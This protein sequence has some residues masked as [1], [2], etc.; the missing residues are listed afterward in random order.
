MGRDKEGREDGA[1]RRLIDCDA[2]TGTEFRS[3]P[4][5]FRR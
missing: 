1:A 5:N 3:R 4:E 2:T